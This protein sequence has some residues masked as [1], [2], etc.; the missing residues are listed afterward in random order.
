MTARGELGHLAVGYVPSA[1]FSREFPQ[2]LHRLQSELPGIVLELREGQ[3]N[4]LSRDLSDGR[5]DI[6]LLRAPVRP[7]DGQEQLLLAP[8][9]LLV[10]LPQ[11]HPL[12]ERKSVVLADLADL[13]MVSYN[14]PNDV[15]IMQV[16]GR[17]AERNGVTLDVC[18]T[19][20]TM[21]GILGL[22]AAGF[23]FGI[24]PAGLD[25]LHPDRILFVPL[26]EPEAQAGL[27]YVWRRDAALPA[28]D[29]FLALVRTD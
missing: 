15:G 18:W 1:L 2:V 9:P 25:Q 23:G 24:V 8:R 20:S 4:D 12:A 17:L 26:A 27:C 19:V 11:G 22:V 16:V 5:I 6:A 28:L 3:I 10:A 21:T 7:A 29:R 13:P 14:D